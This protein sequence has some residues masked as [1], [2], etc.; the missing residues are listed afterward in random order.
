VF[1]GIFYC[2]TTNHGTSLS[3]D[4]KYGLYVLFLPRSKLMPS[5]THTHTHTHTLSRLQSCRAYMLSTADAADAGRPDRKDC[6]SI[7][8]VAAEAATQSASDAIQVI[9]PVEIDVLCQ[10]ISPTLQ[11]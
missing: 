2:F 11:I 6:A 10:T 4:Y 9:Q 5:H 8:L 7:I 3:M 1:F